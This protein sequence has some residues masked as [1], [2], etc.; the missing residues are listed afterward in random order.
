MDVIKTLSLL[1][2][3]NEPQ[4]LVRHDSYNEIIL[5]NIHG[6]VCN[7]P[8]G[9]FTLALRRFPKPFPLLGTPCGHET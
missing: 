8:L 5:Y 4:A 3:H 1:T 7:N 9:L 2:Y 6:P